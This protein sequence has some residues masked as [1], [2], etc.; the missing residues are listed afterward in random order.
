MDNKIDKSFFLSGVTCIP[1]LEI[2]NG[3]DGSLQ[4][5]LIEKL[6]KSIFIYQEHFF[7][8]ILGHD[9]YVAFESTSDDAKWTTMLGKLINTDKHISPLANFVYSYYLEEYKTELT[10]AGAVITK[11]DNMTPMQINHLQ[12]AAWNQMCDMMYLFFRWFRDNYTEL[13]TDN[14]K[15]SRIYWDELTEKTNPYGI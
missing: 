2:N 3:Y 5:N 9:L 8:I 11:K 13:E 6:D 4:A 10:Q 15:L 1:N 7:R 12:T 14:A